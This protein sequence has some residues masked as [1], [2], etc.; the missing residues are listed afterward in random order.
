[1][2]RKYI[3]DNTKNMT[4]KQ[5]LRIRENQ[6]RNVD[7]TEDYCPF[8]IEQRIAELGTKQA[9]RMVEQRRDGGFDGQL[10]AL[11]PAGQQLLNLIDKA[12]ID[13]KNNNCLFLSNN[14]LVHK[15]N[16]GVKMNNSH[17]IEVKYIGPTNT[18]GSRVQLKTYDLSH[19]N[20][21]KPKRKLLSYDYSC[22]GATQQALIFLANS[23][24][25]VIGFNSR[26]PD[27]DVILCDWDFDKLCKI[28]GVEVQS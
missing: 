12:F 3:I 20:G 10:F 26:N 18:L 19:R 2:A 14:V 24:M 4:L 25:K 15:T 9:E 7:C 8:A 11:L 1:M 16:K 5:C 21:N 27:H 23:G 6:Y 28:F 22:D 13:Y 17:L